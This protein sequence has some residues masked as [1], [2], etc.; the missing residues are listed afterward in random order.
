MAHS[1]A[2]ETVLC[3][4]NS[5]LNKLTGRKQRYGF[6]MTDRKSYVSSRREF[7]NLDITAASMSAKEC[8][9]FKVLKECAR[10][11]DK[12]IAHLEREL[13][14]P[15]LFGDPLKATASEEFVDQRIE[16]VI[17]IKE[18]LK[19][20]IEETKH[21][22]EVQKKFNEQLSATKNSLIQQ[23]EEIESHLQKY[24]YKPLQKNYRDLYPFDTPMICDLREE[25]SC[26]GS[27]KTTDDSCVSHEDEVTK[28]FEELNL[29]YKECLTPFVSVAQSRSNN[30]A[31]SNQHYVPRKLVD[32]ESTVSESAPDQTISA[33]DTNEATGYSET[34]Y[35]LERKFKMYKHQK[36]RELPF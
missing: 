1:I 10:N 13:L 32:N 21:S 9:S 34:F 12:K 25:E 7:V 26:D 29:S 2:L 20:L 24:G 6:R 19:K 35:A 31:S 18:N 33:N 28:D 14:S 16:E 22:L 17:D 27:K 23:V 30:V 15:S 3:V 5:D 8:D 11:I 4:G 36:G